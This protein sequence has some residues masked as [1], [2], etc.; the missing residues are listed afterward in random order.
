[1]YVLRALAKG[2]KD[3][4]YK[5]NELVEAY[6]KGFK[7]AVLLQ[8]DEEREEQLKKILRELCTVQDDENVIE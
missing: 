7:D 5:N 4:K 2:R 1:M 6:T 3:M 8:S